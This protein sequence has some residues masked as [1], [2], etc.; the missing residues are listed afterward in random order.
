MM[1]RESKSALPVTVMRKVR[2]PVPNRSLGRCLLLVC[3]LALVLQRDC[4]AQAADTPDSALLKGQGAFLRGAGSYNLNTARAA[5]IN[6][7]TIIRWK[8]DFRKI[9]AERRALREREQAG[10]KQKLEDVKR[11][12]AIREHE[13]RVNPSP[14]DVMNGQALNALL[15]DLTDPDIPSSDW[16]S[17]LVHLPKGMSVKDLIFRFTPASGSSQASQ[18]LGRGVIALSRLGIKGEDWPTVMKPAALDKERVAYESE[19]SKLRNE[20]LADK[21]DLK[22]LQELDRSLDALKSKV[23]TAIPKERGFRDEAA[24]Y[25]EDLKDAT[26]MF[27]AVTV[28]YAR[29]ILRDTKDQDATTVAELVGFMLKYRLQFASAERSPTGGVLYGQIYEAMRQQTTEFGIKPPEPPAAAE[30][31]ASPF[32]P[33]SV[34][35]GENG[36]WIMTVMER[37]GEIFQAMSSSPDGKTRRKITGTVKGNQVSWHSKDVRVIEG[38]PPPAPARDN[39][40]TITTGPDEDK[41]EVVWRDAKGG[42]GTAV[43]RRKRK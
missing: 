14:A 18:V 37:K 28:D 10:K 40:G 39:F 11:R 42:S 24:R 20:L 33:K 13:L 34:W 5:S 41:L 8:Q 17:K 25:V 32:Q 23:Q 38:P 21:F 2:S 7:D 22:T 29:E 36:N 3:G 35:V 15:Y 4:F 30:D 31:V 1:A 26:R 12:L 19:Y 9:D 16:N 6:T 27:D 43:L